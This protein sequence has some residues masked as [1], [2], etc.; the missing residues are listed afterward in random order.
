[1]LPALGWTLAFFL[2]PLILLG[3]YS[4]GEINI[5]TFDVEW[6]WTLDNYSRIFDELYLRPILRSLAAVGGGDGCSACSSASRSR[7]GSPASRGA[8]RRSRWCW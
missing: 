6:G 4:F 1:M 7:S 3:L 5:I 2:G 8:G